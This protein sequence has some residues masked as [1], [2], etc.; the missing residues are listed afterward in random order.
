MSEGFKARSKRLIEEAWNEGRMESVDDAFTS[1][2]VVHHPPFPDIVGPEGVKQTLTE[3]RKAFPDLCMTI[4]EVL[5][6][7]DSGAYHYTVE[8]T[9][10]GE[11]AVLRAPTGK[12][13][14][15]RG[16]SVVRFREGKI[17]EEH[18]YDDNLGML[19]Q[20]GMLGG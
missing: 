1:D 14:V 19:Q 9:H 18:E 12:H 15:W 8:G 7:S 5:V 2:C 20:L 17:A 11:S 4:D 6:D 16:A 10:K 13:V 3:L